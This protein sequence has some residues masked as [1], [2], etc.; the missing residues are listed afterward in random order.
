MLSLPQQISLILPA[1]ER[2]VCITEPFP[3]PSITWFTEAL[4]HCLYALF[5]EGV[6]DFEQV[7]FYSFFSK[8]VL[9]SANDKY[10]TQMAAM[11]CL[12]GKPRLL[13]DIKMTRHCD[14]TRQGTLALFNSMWQF[15]IFGL[16]F[17]LCFCL[18][19]VFTA[20]GGL[21]A[22]GSARGF[23]SDKGLILDCTIRSAC[24]A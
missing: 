4:F 11:V 1:R 19:F 14:Q 12:S 8:G 10:F 9:M 22:V 21:L 5:S 17:I 23:F 2:F 7:W 13:R 18:L 6:F 15:F 3:T 16:L 20:G 24:A